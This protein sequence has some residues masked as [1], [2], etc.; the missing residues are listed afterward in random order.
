[1]VYEGEKRRESSITVIHSLA[2]IVGKGIQG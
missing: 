2:N 1:M